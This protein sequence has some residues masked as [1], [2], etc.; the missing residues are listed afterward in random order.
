MKMGM[1][2]DD[3]NRFG[4]EKWLQVTMT[5]SRR[6]KK[7]PT[8]GTSPPWKLWNTLF[9]NLRLYL[10]FR[11]SMANSMAYVSWTIASCHYSFS[12][13][14][15]EAAAADVVCLCC[16]DSA[17]LGLCVCA[18]TVIALCSVFSVF[19]S[20]F[21]LSKSFSGGIF[22]RLWCLRTSRW[23]WWWWWRRSWTARGCC[24]SNGFTK[25][26][27]SRGSKRARY[28][29]WKPGV[30]SNVLVCGFIFGKFMHGTQHLR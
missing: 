9:A 22:P 8:V 21:L 1:A 25:R 18:L 20:A 27:F 17:A 12:R 30:T 13:L 5:T 2:Y 3:I 16:L 7:L 23:W 11:S 28:W 15:I 4:D 6:Y 24:C 19:L 10:C 29:P 14:G 26:C